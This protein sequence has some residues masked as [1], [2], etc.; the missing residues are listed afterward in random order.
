MKQTL[1]KVLAKHA[2]PLRDKLERQYA[3]DQTADI[4][5]I[6]IT[7]DSCRYDAYCDAKTPILD[8]FGSTLPAQSPATYTY[9]AHQSFFVGILPNGSDP[10]P[11]YNR[12]TRQLI[13][14]I[15]VGETPTKKST[16]FTVAS[17]KDAIDGFRKAGFQTVGTGAMNWFR[18]TSLISSFE[19]FAMLK[20][21]E[22][23]VDYILEKLDRSRPFFAFMNFGETHDPFDYRGKSVPCPVRVQARLMSWPPSESGPVGRDHEAYWHQVESI[24]FLD[25]QLGRLFTA[26]PANTVAIL[27]G[28]HGECFGED[29]YWG[30]GVNHPKVF[31]VPLSIFRLDRQPIEDLPN[32]L[33]N[34]SPPGR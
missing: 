5:F 31:E 18:Q 25:R 10:L 19:Q 2:P 8:S 11:Y 17:D 27:C 6:L 3:R 15:E 29:G 26:L 13:G 32:I 34:D 33:S 14:L 12:F 7:F 30:H 22:K 23:Q 16:Y 4:N 9:A 28:D 24:E 20:D 1:K 21:A